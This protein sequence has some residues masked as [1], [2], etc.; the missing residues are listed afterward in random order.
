MLTMWVTEDEHRRLLE[1]CDGRQLAAWKLQACLDE[2]LQ[3]SGDSPSPSLAP[4]RQFAGMGNNP[5]PDEPAALT[6]AA[7]LAMTG[8]RLWRR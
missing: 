5:D 1:R 7:A 4:Q 3:R 2:R 6:P 8:C